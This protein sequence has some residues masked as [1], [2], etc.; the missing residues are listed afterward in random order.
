MN[1]YKFDIR[2]LEKKYQASVLVNKKS[3]IKF[4]YIKN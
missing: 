3:N 1:V 2:N 4:L